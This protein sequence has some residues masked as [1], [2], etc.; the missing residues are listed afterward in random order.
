MKLTK[1]IKNRREKGFTMIELMIA[2]SIFGFILLV[3]SI[4][5]ITIGKVYHKGIISSRAQETSRSVMDD[6]SASLQFSAPGS[7][8]ITPVP[9]AD[10]S[11]LYSVCFGNDKYTYKIYTENPNDVGL[12]RDKL[13]NTTLCEPDNNLDNQGEQLLGDNMRLLKF[14]VGTD[15][16]HSV[17]IIVAY[18]DD[19]LLTAYEDD[20][21]YKSGFNIEEAQ[22]KSS[23]FGGTFCAVSGLETVV[24]RRL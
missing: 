15:N 6:I 11:D 20:G 13:E 24:S 23:I 10:E 12:K 19:D 17:A 4:A 7:S 3:A 16:P 1:N 18:G 5:I 14:E 21:V 8:T 9:H 2:T 22:C